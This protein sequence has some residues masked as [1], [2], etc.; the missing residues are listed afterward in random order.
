[1]KPTATFC[2]L[3][4]VSSSLFSQFNTGSNSAEAAGF[5][6]AAREQ[7]NPVEAKALCLRALEEDTIFVDARNYLAEL[8]WELEMSDSA[9]HFY[10]SSLD[11][12]PRGV[13]AHEGLARMYQAQEEYDAAI[14]QYQQ[15]L[16]HYPNYPPAFYG[17]AWV[18]FNQHD[19]ESSIENSEKALRLYLA[20][21]RPEPAADAR[22]LAA[23]AYLKDG[24]YNRAIKYFKASKKRF[25]DK[26]YYYYH[27]GE[28][29]LMAGKKEKAAELFTQAENMG[30]NLPVHLKE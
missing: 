17:M 28:C 8:Y 22:M 13:H 27:L 11:K 6:A 23:Q 26:P 18:Y 25:G 20:A 3:L 12:Y 2:L 1:M 5:F 10:Q 15:L 19:F 7:T 16:R 4:F 14:F 30:Y 9:M 21:N 24:N 29:Y